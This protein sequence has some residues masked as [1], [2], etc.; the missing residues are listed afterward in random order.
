MNKLKNALG[1]L[2]LDMDFFNEMKSEIQT[3]KLVTEHGL[4]K[5]TDED[6]RD[7]LG[8]LDTSVEDDP[9]DEDDE[10]QVDMDV[11]SPHMREVYQ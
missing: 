11:L 6:V 7:E 1:A 9:I 10:N 5:T 3:E 2:G 8:Q 4:L